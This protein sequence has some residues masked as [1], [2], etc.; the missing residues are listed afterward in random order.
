MNTTTDIPEIHQEAKP[1][2]YEDMANIPT[3]QLRDIAWGTINESNRRFSVYDEPL[4]GIVTLI[5]HLISYGGLLLLGDYIL[6]WFTGVEVLT[7]DHTHYAWTYWVVL[8]GIV[9]PLTWLVYHDY[10]R[11]YRAIFPGKPVAPTRLQS[12]SGGDLAGENVAVM[13]T[14]QERADAGDKEARDILYYI[15]KFSNN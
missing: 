5:V 6:S 12:L 10:I 1:I 8:A 11:W 2:T 13:I 14:L 4:P 3:K 7:P 15:G 9:I